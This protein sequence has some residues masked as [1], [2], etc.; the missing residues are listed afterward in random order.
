MQPREGKGRQSL[1]SGSRTAV[2]VVV[3]VAF[4]VY[5][6]TA[7]PVALFNHRRLALVVVDV[8]NA[9]LAAVLLSVDVSVTRKLVSARKR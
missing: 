9:L 3:L 6:D 2:E 4:H 7:L 1:H 8:E 5:A